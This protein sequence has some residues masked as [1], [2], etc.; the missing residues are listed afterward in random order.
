MANRYEYRVCTLQLNR[1][2]FVNGEWQGTVDPAA[3]DP[4]AALGSCP[5]AWDYLNQA[6]QDG[7]ELVGAFDQPAQEGTHMQ[8]LFLKR[9]LT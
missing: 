3:E 4:N 7:W 2:T 9:E 8:T 1:V 5:T 6:G